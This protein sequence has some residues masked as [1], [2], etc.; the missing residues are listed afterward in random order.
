MTVI[1]AQGEQ[2][3][4]LRPELAAAARALARTT[5]V[6][7]VCGALVVGVLSRLGMMLL[8]GLNPEATGIT[9]DD[10]FEMG[11]FTLSG[12]LQLLASGLQFG[13]AGAW[14]YVV[15]RGLMVGPPWFRLL[16]IS[17]GPAVVVGA[18]VVHTGGVD[19]TLL[20]P[21]W[22]TVAMFVALPGLFVALL[23]LGVERAERRG[24]VLPRSLTALGLLPWAVLLPLTVPLAAGFLVQRHLRAR[25]AGRRLLHVGAWAARAVLLGVFCVALADLAR[26][27][28]FLTSL[29]G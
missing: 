8:A 11:Q 20:E 6:G 7:A 12:S 29:P 13:V 9:S 18:V 17:T 19:F 25:D 16:S 21:V 3:E 5:L 22:L 4:G 24:A 14:C 28:E 10:G 26:D 23:H 27:V 15:V 1:E 2:H